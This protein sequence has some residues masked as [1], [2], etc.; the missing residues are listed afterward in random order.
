MFAVGFILSE[1]VHFTYIIQ[2]SWQVQR[3][4]RSHSVSLLYMM[5]LIM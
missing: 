2:H 4:I 3:D 1:L 5:Q